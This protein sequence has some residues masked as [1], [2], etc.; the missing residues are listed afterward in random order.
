VLLEN[1]KRSRWNRVEIA[2]ALGL[3]DRALR[4][5]T[6]GPYQLQAAIAALHAQAPSSDQ[7]DW[8]RIAALYERLLAV[9]PTPVVALNHAVAVAMATSPADG[10][11]LID[12]IEGLDRYHLLHAAR[13]DL[14]R[15]LGRTTQ[16]AAAYQRA[17]ELATNAAD[18]RFL[19]G[20]L[21]ALDGAE[22]T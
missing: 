22:S 5:E 10:L 8:P 6:I 12:R 3:L 14:L 13:A 4:H 16:A 7:I 15:R 11:A 18:R 20:R 9:A 21:L 1:Q 17:H 19:A 2:E